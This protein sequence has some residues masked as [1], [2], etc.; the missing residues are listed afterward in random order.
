M[1]VY[2]LVSLIGI[3][4]E[5]LASVSDST[6]MIEGMIAQSMSASGNL[7]HE[8]RILT[9]VVAYHEERGLHPITIENVEDEGCRF[10]DGAVEGFGDSAG[11]PAGE[12]PAGEAEGAE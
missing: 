7:L 1:G 12:E 3:A 10:R 8:L 2:Q 11:E 6:N 4:Q 9:H 5:G